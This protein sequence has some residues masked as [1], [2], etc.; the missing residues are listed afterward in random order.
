MKSKDL[1]FL[2][3]FAGILIFSYTGYGQVNK[4]QVIGIDSIINSPF[5]EQAPV[6]SPDG[7]ALYFTI[8]KHPSN[9]GGRKDKG[10]IWVSFK[11]PDEKWLNPV[12]IGEP[13]N[14]NQYNAVVGFSRDGNRMYLIG[15]Y[16]AIDKRSKTKG[17]SVSEKRN[18]K[19]SSPISLD[20]PYFS[21]HSNEQSACLSYDG[22]IMLHSIES[23]NSRGAEDLYVSFRKTDGSWTDVRNLGSEINSN[24]QEK[25]PFLSADNRTL[26][27]SSNGYGGMGSMD[28]FMS[29]RLDDSWKNWSKPVNMGQPINSPGRELYFFVIPGMEDAVFCSTQNSDGYGD[30]KYYQLLPEDIIPPIEEVLIATDTLVQEFVIER[31]SLVFMGSTYNAQNNEPVPATISIFLNDENEIASI[32]TDEGTGKYQLEISSNNEFLI[33]VGSK[34]FMNVEERVTLN[35]FEQ[36]IILRSYYLEP[37]EIG[38]VFKLNSVLF[39]RASSN[40]IDSSFAELNNV[41]RMLGDNPD[42]SIELSG[43]TDNVGNAR[44]NVELSTERVEVVRQY[45][46]VKGINAGRI[47]GKGYGGTKPIASNRNEETRR[48]NRRV[49]FK[50]VESQE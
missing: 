50:V 17:I 29:K 48:L 22:S 47:T 1:F 40:L 12:N 43:H 25:T 24:F 45:L 37:L 7:E 14:N 10:D 39:E 27:F 18:G 42:I 8:S 20:I 34:G 4:Y 32:E 26:I 2:V 41:F 23:Y 11:D 44:K 31:N 28:L 6:F 36:N 19:W 5:D 46:I 16:I 30:I 3:I 15:H 49:E 13:V 21:N 33:R 9:I 35:D 38:K